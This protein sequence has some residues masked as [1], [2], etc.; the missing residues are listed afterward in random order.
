MALFDIQLTSGMRS[1]LLTLKRT[2]KD[3]DKTQQRLSSGH[4]VNSALDNPTNFFAAQA[5]INRA[6]DLNERKDLIREAIQTIKTADA[7]IT[8]ISTLLQAAN[9]VANAAR[10]TSDQPSIDGFASQF[11]EIL[12]QIDT[13]TYDSSYRGTNLLNNQTMTVDFAEQAGQSFLQISGVDATSSG[14]GL[15]KVNAAGTT[16]PVATGAAVVSTPIDTPSF[17]YTGFPLTTGEPFTF[18]IDNS[19]NPHTTPTTLADTVITPVAYLMVNGVAGDL[20]ITDIAFSGDS[21]SMTI[22]IN[23][24]TADIFPGDTI[25][26]VFY[27][28]DQIERTFATDKPAAE[29]TNLYVDGTLMVPGTDYDLATRAGDGKADIVFTVGHEP[30]DGAAITADVTTGGSK[31]PTGLQISMEQLQAAV[32]AVRSSSNVLANN[33]GILTTRIDFTER[34][35]GILQTGAEKL[36]LADMNEEGANMLMLQVR[37]SLATNSL[38]MGVEAAQAVVRLF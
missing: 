9:G 16:V 1:S 37:Q 34:L 35:M 25:Q 29:F 18:P 15:E 24:L 5:H 23:S 6:A 3:I 36:T 21:K 20:A 26:F 13:I 12:S 32:E 10:G 8:A 22:T 17:P 38:S 33:T 31:W 11:D 28:D 14:L 19:G 7:G 27:P 4:K 30:P 2:D